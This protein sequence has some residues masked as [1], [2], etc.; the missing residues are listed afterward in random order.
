[1]SSFDFLDSEQSPED[2]I[3]ASL[4]PNYLDTSPSIFDDVSISVSES[5]YDSLEEYLINCA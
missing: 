5:L 4:D 3:T 1:M 2:A